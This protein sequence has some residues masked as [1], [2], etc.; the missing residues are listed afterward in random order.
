MITALAHLSL[1]SMVS[2]ILILAGLLITIVQAQELDDFVDAHTHEFQPTLQDLRASALDQARFQQQQSNRA[3]NFPLIIQD[4][5]FTVIY[6]ADGTGQ[7]SYSS[8][9]AQIS[10]LNRDFSGEDATVGG[11]G[12]ATDSRIRFR[13]GAIRYLQNDD[14]HSYCSSPDAQK[15]M[16]S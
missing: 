1:E 11:Y 7:V 3:I 9:I 5:M 2:V 4:V 6:K 16:R 15:V 14:I 10:E 8:L 12:K 13:L